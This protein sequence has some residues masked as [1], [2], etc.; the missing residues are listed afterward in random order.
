MFQRSFYWCSFW[1]RLKITPNKWRFL[2]WP[3]HF[4]QEKWFS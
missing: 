1:A 4:N 2:T 3:A